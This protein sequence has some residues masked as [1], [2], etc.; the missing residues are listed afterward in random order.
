MEDPGG[1]L[2]GPRKEWQST[3]PLVVART[4]ALG[5]CSG[6]SVCKVLIDTV[7]NKSV[8]IFATATPQTQT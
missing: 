2:G 6:V 3:R 7:D 1:P 8:A 4:S 5:K